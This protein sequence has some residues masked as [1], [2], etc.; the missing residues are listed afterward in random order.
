MYNGLIVKVVNSSKIAIADGISIPPGFVSSVAIER[1][2]LLSL[3]KP[4]SDCDDLDDLERKSE[5]YE[6][7]AKSG[8]KYRQSDCFNLYFQRTIIQKCACYFPGL[9]KF[10]SSSQSC[11]NES[12]ISCFNGMLYEFNTRI[13]EYKRIYSLECPLECD[14]VSYDFEVSSLS[15]FSREYFESLPAENRVLNASYDVY[16]ESF[17]VLNV[18]YLTTQHTEIT[19]AAKI[20][21]VDLV[22]N[23]GGAIGVFLG[24][25]VFSLV[26]IAEL[27]VQL[28]CILVS[29]MRKH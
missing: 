13:S 18:Y 16:K 29:K 23:L 21:F 7:I 2:F 22:A 3:P 20:T 12:Q 14:S 17:L 1:Y 5:L 4:Y 15:I 11:L 27:C 19:Q 6:F 25:S 8:Q 28:G 24:F 10:D 9:P 26:E